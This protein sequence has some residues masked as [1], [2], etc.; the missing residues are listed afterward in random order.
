MRGHIPRS[1]LELGYKSALS[2]AFSL[3]AKG[4]RCFADAKDSTRQMLLLFGLSSRNYR[5]PYLV[6]WGFVEI[7]VPQELEVICDQTLSPSDD[8]PLPRAVDDVQ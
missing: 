8:A 4:L 5:K 1:T 7:F 3:A 2:S 6:A